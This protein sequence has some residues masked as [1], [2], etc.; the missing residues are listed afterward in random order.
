MFSMLWVERESS[1]HLWADVNTTNNHDMVPGR[2]PTAERHVLHP[3]RL[4]VCIFAM[5]T[6]GFQD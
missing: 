1:P 6:R 4:R 2:L 3:S 5:V